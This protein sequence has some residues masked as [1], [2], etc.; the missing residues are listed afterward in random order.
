MNSG[1]PTAATTT[2]ALATIPYRPMVREWLWF[3]L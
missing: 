1:L 2:F 3:N